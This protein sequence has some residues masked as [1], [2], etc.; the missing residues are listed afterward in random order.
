MRLRQL[1]KYG[2]SVDV[3]ALV[4][5]HIISSFFASIRSKRSFMSRKT[6]P[7][8]EAEPEIVCVLPHPVAPYAK[9]VALYPSNTPGTSVLA[10]PLKT[11]CCVAASSKTL[12][13][14]NLRSLVFLIPGPSIDF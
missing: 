1:C 9:A 10:A 13:K 2:K 14:Q 6:M 8:S 5:S 4:T 3:Y 12:S 7:G 11:S